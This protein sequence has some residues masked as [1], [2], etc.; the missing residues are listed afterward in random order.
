[1]SKMLSSI[2]V[3]L[4]L[5]LNIAVV[6]AGPPMQDFYAAVMKMTPQGKLGQVIKQEK[7]STSI[8]DAQAWRIAYISSDIS[9]RKTIS[10]GLVAWP[11][12]INSLEH[13]EG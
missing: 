8:K 7:V 10:T 13:L 11:F 3:G 2:V 12:G 4:L 6:H 9:G 1:M 5:S